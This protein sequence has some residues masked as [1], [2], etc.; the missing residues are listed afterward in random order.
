LRL[1]APIGYSPWIYLFL[2][3]EKVAKTH[4]RILLPPIGRNKASSGSFLET[5]AE[6]ISALRPVK[7]YMLFRADYASQAGAL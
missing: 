3:A 7:V 6:G 1:R 5:K 2:F 4:P